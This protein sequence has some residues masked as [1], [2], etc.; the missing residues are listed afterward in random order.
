MVV[1]IWQL[2][3][4]R[5]GPRVVAV[6]ASGWQAVSWHCPRPTGRGGAAEKSK[7]STITIKYYSVDCRHAVNSN[8]LV[9]FFVIK[10]GK[11]IEAN[12]VND[13][14]VRVYPRASW[15]YPTGGTGVDM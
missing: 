14:D 15:T 12:A 3:N 8:R 10:P 13:G 6:V 2:S 5:N 1:R 9:T 4:V 11:I 7:L